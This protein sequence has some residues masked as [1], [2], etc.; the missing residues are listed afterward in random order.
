MRASLRSFSAFFLATLLVWSLPAGANDYLTADEPDAFIVQLRDVSLEQLTDQS[1]A[2]E[3]R[4]ARFQTLLN[5]GFDV[6]AV[7][8]FVLAKYWRQASDNERQMFKTVFSDVLTARF[9]PVFDLYQEGMDL[10]VDRVSEAGNSGQVFDVFS[11]LTRPG[12]EP[13]KIAWR[14]L[15]RDGGD[16][17]IV[18]VRVENLSMAITLRSEYTTQLQRNGG[19]VSGLIDDLKQRLAS[20]AVGDPKLTETN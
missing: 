8:S 20:G 13:V 19:S 16:F 4:R 12:E 10:T 15:K 3:D 17:K 7:S 11:T 18:D 1:V 2:S 14:L 9:L 6:E 5:E